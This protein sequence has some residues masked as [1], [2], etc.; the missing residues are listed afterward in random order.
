PAARRY[1]VNLGI[2]FQLTNILRDLTA[3]AGRG[4]VYLPA[5]DLRRFGYAESDLLA[6]RYS[7]AFVELMRFQAGRARNFFRACRA[8]LGREDRGKLYAA[9]VM[10]RTYEKVLARIEAC[11]YD[12]F[13]NR[14]R[15]P[16]RQKLW[17]AGRT[18]VALRVLP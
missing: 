2:A 4:R 5:E 17:I 12:V 7:P 8:S 3:D 14:V 18:W 1:A 10:R 15:L 16:G 13:R 6:R 11:G 9:E